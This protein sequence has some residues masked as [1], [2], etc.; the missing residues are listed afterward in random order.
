LLKTIYP[1]LIW[2]IP[3]SKPTIFL[4]FD[5]GPV[6]KATEFVLNQL[7]INKAKATFFCIGENIIK[8]PTIFNEIVS[9]GH[10]IGNHTMNHLNG[11]STGNEQYI[12]NFND[13]QSLIPDATLFRPPYGKI[14]KSQEIIILKT[15]K[16]IM[17]DVISYDFS[18]DLKPEI[19]LE[20]CIKYTRSGTVI[21]FHD[22]LKAYKNL[23]YVLP[24]YI[25]HFKEKGFSFEPIIF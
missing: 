8:N 11:W 9:N 7:E 18:V 3:I 22:S 13:C 25:A 20:K 16:I 4:T 5:D 6:P 24:K 19:C 2:E 23:S 12:K 21:V 1:K 17:W 14:R 10:S 15:H